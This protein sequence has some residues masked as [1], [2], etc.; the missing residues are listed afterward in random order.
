MYAGWRCAGRPCSLAGVFT[1]AFGWVLAPWVVHL[2]F[3][4][5]T[6]TAGDT[7]TVARLLRFGLLQLPFYFS[8]L[9]FVSL[10]S[11]QGRY[12][13]LLMS[14]VLGLS[15]KAVAIYYL[16][17][18]FSVGALMLSGVVVYAANTLLLA[19]AYFR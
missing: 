9:V 13:L 7:L 2:L 12:R 16:L 15:A 8:T 6:F 11:S 14:G 17:D 4:R 5:G 1:L 19:N 10:H 18:T 3:E